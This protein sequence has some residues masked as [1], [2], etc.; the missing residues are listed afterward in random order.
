MVKQVFK[1]T[2]FEKKINSD[3]VECKVMKLKYFNM[4]R[5]TINYNLKLISKNVVKTIVMLNNIA[6]HPLSSRTFE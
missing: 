4:M 5:I 6:N 3:N 1:P 2:K